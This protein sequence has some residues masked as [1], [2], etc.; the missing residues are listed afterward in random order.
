MGTIAHLLDNKRDGLYLQ[1]A[2]Y[3]FVSGLAFGFNRPLLMLAHDPLTVPIDYADLLFIHNTAAA[4]VSHTEEWLTQVV[5]IVSSE[6]QRLQEQHRNIDNI[7]ALRKI[8][9]GEDVAENEQFDLLDYFIP[10]AAYEDAFRS[11]QTMIYVGRKGSG[12]TANLYKIVDELSSDRR[13]HVC[14]IKPVAYELEG[15]LKLL[16]M[17][18][19]RAEKGFMLQ[20]LW[21]FLVYTELAFSVYEELES[22]PP[23]FEKAEEEKEFLLFVEANRD[24]IT[25]EFAIRMEKAI[26]DLCEID[27]SDLIENQR[28]R[29]SEILHNNILS[30]LRDYLGKVLEKKERVCV[31]VDNLDKSWIRGSDINLLADFLFALLSVSKSITDEFIK[32]GSVTWKPVKLSLLIFLRSDIFSFVMKEARERDKLSFKRMEWTDPFLL[33]QIIE[34]R[35]LKSTN[36]TLKSDDVWKEY[37]VE[38]IDDMPTKDYLVSRIIPRPRDIIYLCRS[39]LAHAVNHKHDRIEAVDIKQAEKEYSQYAFN[40]VEA[41]TSTQLE[42][43]EELLYEFVSV[44]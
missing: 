16:R 18:A 39:A 27:F 11:P 35:F 24:F 2:K 36:R 42:H 31:L 41:E 33:Q 19:S 25:S 4:C 10:T 29:V 34:E 9:L 22:K 37:F 3:S 12:K 30:R 13:N 5:E 7:I 8:N 43:F 38:T 23:Y 1:N 17:S 26:K 20:A 15:I 14:S 44:N 6:R 21:K 32:K 40:S 28:K